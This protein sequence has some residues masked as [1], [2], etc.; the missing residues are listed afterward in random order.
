MIDIDSIFRYRVRDK[1]KLL[2]NGFCQTDNGYF[3]E[4]P[5]M[6][7]QFLMAVSITESG[8]VSI[9]VF[10]KET[11]AEYIL[12]HVS[13]ANGGFVGEVRN[14]CETALTDIAQCCFTVE[15]FKAEQTKRIIAA[16]HAQYD[17]QPEFPWDDGNAVFRN[18]KNSKWFGIILTIDRNKLGLP[19]RGSIEIMNLKDTP[20][21][22][23]KYTSAGKCFKA[24][25][26]N[27]KHWYTIP[28]DGTLSDD[29]IMILIARSYDLVEKK[30]KHTGD[31]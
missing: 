2:A 19:E 6:E 26:M 8:K 27:K 20:E 24:Y 13:S 23:K 29:E 31:S 25:H 28:L 18:A 12:V 14:A 16:I 5:I 22:V 4:I 1:A 30:R 7:D 10:E 21:S 17:V 3:G 15:T 9:K 11:G